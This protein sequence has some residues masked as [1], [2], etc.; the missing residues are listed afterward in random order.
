MQNLYFKIE[1]IN[2]SRAH[3]APYE[4]TPPK[5]YFDLP[6]IVSE[7]YNGPPESPISYQIKQK[8]YLQTGVKKS[9]FDI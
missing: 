6:L 9:L 1:Y 3:P 7:T 2:P 5:T 8:N 4:V